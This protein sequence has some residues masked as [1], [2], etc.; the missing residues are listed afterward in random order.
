MKRLGRGSL[1]T[2][3]CLITPLL[4]PILV[5]NTARSSRGIWIIYFILF[6]L[7][8]LIAGLVSASSKFKT[9]S[10]ESPAIETKYLTL[11]VSL[12]FSFP[13][14]MLISIYIA[15]RVDQN[16]ALNYWAQQLLNTLGYVFRWVVNLQAYYGAWVSAEQGQVLKALTVVSVWFI[17]GIF[18]T[19]SIAFLAF[20]DNSQTSQGHASVVARDSLVG[21]PGMQFLCILFGL[22][23][24]MSAY[25]GWFEFDNASR[26]K[27]CLVKVRCYVHDDLAI[28]GAAIFK[29]FAI[30]G[31]GGGVIQIF[32]QFMK[33]AFK[34]DR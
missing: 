31:F 7:A 9:E 27:Y 25:F 1:L 23:V 34:T 20:A 6:A 14:V 12:V 30:F 13:L 16:G 19:L 22:C 18:C 32:R 2:V 5:E 29:F 3:V 26:M 8:V 28:I 21:R 11:R 33:D 17:Y 10:P 4:P 24:V 15:N